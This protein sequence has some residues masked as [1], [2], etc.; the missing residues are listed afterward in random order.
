MVA[1]KTDALNVRIDPD[2]KEV[3]MPL[4]DKAGKRVNNCPI[5]TIGS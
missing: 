5:L 1:K 4:M 2:L 3:L